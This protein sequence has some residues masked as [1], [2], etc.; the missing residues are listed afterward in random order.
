[1]TIQ[2]KK[3]FAAVSYDRCDPG[4]CDPEKGTCPAAKACSYKVIKQID[5]P[6]EP[7]MVF[8]D[9]CMGC[10]ECIEACPLGAVE[11]KQTT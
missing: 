3:S 8:F 2:S 7:P 11:R 4:R 1:M 6:F 5:G 10:W 9:L